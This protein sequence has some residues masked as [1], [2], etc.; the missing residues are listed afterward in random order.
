MQAMV[1]DALHINS[2]DNN[3]TMYYYWIQ[4]KAAKDYLI[5]MRVY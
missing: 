4:I 1:A 5:Y 3:K 2:Q